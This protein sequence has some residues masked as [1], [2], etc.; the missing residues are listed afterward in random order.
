MVHFV[1]PPGTTAS[2]LRL[3]S[4]NTQRTSVAADESRPRGEHRLK[5]P[6]ISRRHDCDRPA[7]SG[8]GVWDWSRGSRDTEPQ[9]Q[10]PRGPGQLRWCSRSPP[11]THLPH[12]IQQGCF[13]AAV[14]NSSVQK[15]QVPPEGGETPERG[16]GCATPFLLGWGLLAPVRPARLGLARSLRLHRGAR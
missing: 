11:G 10:R 16:G 15:G 8:P 2:S 4:V 14:A 5:W 3:T 13:K 6:G 9:S 1:I 12:G 7:A